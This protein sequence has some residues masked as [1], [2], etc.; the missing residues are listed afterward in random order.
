MDRPTT[1]GL[2]ISRAVFLEALRKAAVGLPA[3]AHAA[4]AVYEP[5]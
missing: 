1:M 3:T 5:K 4:I 2:D